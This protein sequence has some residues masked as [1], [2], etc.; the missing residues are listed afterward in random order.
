MKFGWFSSIILAALLSVVVFGCKKVDDKDKT[1]NPVPL[2]AGKGDGGNI[3]F[4]IVPMHDGV[5]VDSCKV[6]IK[7]DDE[8][9]PERTNLYDDSLIC[10]QENGKPVA[11]FY[12][13]R[14]GTYLFYADGWDLIRSQAVEGDRVVLA[15]QERTIHTLELQLHAK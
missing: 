8:V 6:Y 1:P 9:A 15:D 14:K 13:L 5:E 2:G 12:E 3:T 7:Y 10:V 4:R 11:T